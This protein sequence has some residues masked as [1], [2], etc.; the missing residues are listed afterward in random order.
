MKASFIVYFLYVCLLGLLYYLFR[1]SPPHFIGKMPQIGIFDLGIAFIAFIPFWIA[2]HLFSLWEKRNTAKPPYIFYRDMHFSE[3]EPFWTALE[4][5][6]LSTKYAQLRGQLKTA[7]YIGYDFGKKFV[8]LPQCIRLKRKIERW[9]EFI[10]MD[11]LVGTKERGFQLCD[12]CLCDKDH[13]DS[14][15]L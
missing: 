14:E 5:L 7:K 6:N 1:I 15:G 4:T 11:S 10:P 9:Y 3:D 2:G 8:H 12:R 13:V